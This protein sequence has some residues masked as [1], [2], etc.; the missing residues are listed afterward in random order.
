MTFAGTRTRLRCLSRPDPSFTLKRVSAAR[1]HSSFTNACRAGL[2]PRAV[3]AGSR[4]MAGY[5]ERRTHAP[6]ARWIPTRFPQLDQQQRLFD[7]A[8][9]ASAVNYEAET[10]KPTTTPVVTVSTHA[11]TPAQCRDRGFV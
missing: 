10:T 9:S 1:C 3:I 2:R 7:A 5:G 6:I 8:R 11:T 4:V